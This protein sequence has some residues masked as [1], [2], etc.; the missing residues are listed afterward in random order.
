MFFFLFGQIDNFSLPTTKHCIF[1][2]EACATIGGM[3]VYIE[4]VVLDNFVL[5]T[6]LLWAA[7]K[8]LHLPFAKWRIALGGAVGTMAAVASVWVDGVWLYLLKA[9]CLLA[10]C[11]TVAGVGRKLFWYIL[12]TVAYTFGAGGAIVGLF[13]LLKADFVQGG[14]FYNMQVPLFVYVLGA[15]AVGF[16]CYS[17]GVYLRQAR[18]IAPHIVAVVVTLHKSYKVSGFCDSGN[19]VVHNGLPVCFVTKRFGGFADYLAQQTLAHNTV[20]LSVDTVA[21]SVNVQAVHATLSAC[22]LTKEVLLALPAAKCATIYNV[23]LSSEFC[24]GQP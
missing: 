3:N 18:R 12:L 20:Q 10:M 5:D 2:A 1:V 16:V 22:G 23:L 13:Y 6:L 14:A 4:Y 7:A 8:T 17:T 11:A 15:V 24:G 9:A 19:T 21:G